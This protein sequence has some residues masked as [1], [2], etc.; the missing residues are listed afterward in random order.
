ME[1]E[2]KFAKIPK[3]IKITL[4]IIIIITVA[5]IAYWQ[6]QIHINNQN[7]YDYLKANDYKQNSDNIYFKTET[8]STTTTTDKAISSEYLFARDITHDDDTYSFISLQ[9]QKDGTINITYQM[10][11]FDSENNYGVLY[12]EGTYKGGKFECNIVTNTNFKTK[13]NQMKQ[14]AQKYNKEI[15]N[16]LTNNKINLKFVNIK[17]KKTDKV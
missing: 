3:I 6:I 8:E 7:L 2:N 14:E 10:E 1:D 17:S 16:I 13:C 11:G 12:Q 5:I 4:T 9:Y 15:E